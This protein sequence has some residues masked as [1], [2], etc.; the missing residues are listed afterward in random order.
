LSAS[1]L[2]IAN[3]A[4]RQDFRIWSDTSCSLPIWQASIRRRTG[5]Q[6]PMRI[7][8]RARSTEARAL[9]FHAIWRSSFY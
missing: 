2:Q 6:L 9:R 8:T 4:E 1:S 5:R 3:A 7:R